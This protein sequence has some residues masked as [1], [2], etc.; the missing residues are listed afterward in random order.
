[1]SLADLT[2]VHPSRLVFG[3]RWNLH[4]RKVIPQRLRLY[5]IDTVLS[6]ILVIFIGIVFKNL[7]IMPLTNPVIRHGSV[8]EKVKEL[9]ELRPT[10]PTV[11]RPKSGDGST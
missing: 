6:F 5:K 8:T 4:Q 1:M 10:K 2:K 7:G 11:Q 3:K 9:A